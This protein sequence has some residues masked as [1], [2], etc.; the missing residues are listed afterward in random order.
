MDTPAKVEARAA[1]AAVPRKRE[2]T[3]PD[4]WVGPVRRRPPPPGAE[5]PFR[6]GFR[7]RAITTPD[8]RTVLEQSPFTPRDLVYPQEGD[9]VA[10]GFPHNWFLHPLADAIRRHLGKR[11]ATLVICSTMLVLGDGNNAGPDIAVIEGDVDIS[12]IRRAVNLRAMSG[13]LVFVLEAVSTSDKADQ[14]QG[15]RDQ[16]GALR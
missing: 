7:E 14:G 4:S 5:D 13:R 11:P 16:R 1:T 9:V 10:D 12:G 3:V 2:G 6:L 8:G 15:P